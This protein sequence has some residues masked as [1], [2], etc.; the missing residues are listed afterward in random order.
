MDDIEQVNPFGTEA[1]VWIRYFLGKLGA[2]YS[3][4]FGEQAMVFKVANK[5]F[6]LISIHKGQLCMN[7]KCDP[8]QALELRDL[9]AC[10]QPGYHM[11]KKHWNTIIF[12]GSLP[13]G[14]LQ[15]QIDHSY[16]LI[17]SALP[18]SQRVTLSLNA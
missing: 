16:E 13:E 17:V 5:M 2:N 7:L 4:P 15:R 1:E 18:K 3:F 8:E 14:E 10:V 11:N 6:G 9:F 12:D